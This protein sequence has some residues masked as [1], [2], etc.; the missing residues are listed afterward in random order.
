MIPERRCPH[1]VDETVRRLTTA[2]EGLGWVVSG[3]SDLQQSIKKHGGGDLRAV[4]LV[5]FCKAEHAA[6][7]L[8]VDAARRVS[9][10]MPC[11]VSVYQK[12]DGSVWVSSLNARLI[13]PLFGGVIAEVMGDAVARDQ[14]RILDAVCD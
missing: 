1:S 13:S 3:V 4:K 11:T 8:G 5:N 10:L 6:R 9:V 12:T 14:A 2:A 7:I